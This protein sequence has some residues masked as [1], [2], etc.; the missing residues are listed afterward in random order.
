ML[1]Y[2]RQFIYHPQTVILPEGVDCSRRVYVVNSRANFVESTR[3]TA[4][5][6]LRQMYLAT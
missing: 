6:S 4:V 3:V 1:K 5:L 2:D